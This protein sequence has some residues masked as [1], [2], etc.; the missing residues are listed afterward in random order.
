M[1]RLML[2][3][4]ASLGYATGYAQTATPAPDAAKPDKDTHVLEKFVVT[5]SNIPMASDQLAVPMT[6]I[7]SDQI[8]DSGEATS[9]LDLLRKISP[10]ISGI[11]EENATIS[12]AA[13]YGGSLI[14]L[15]GLSVLILVN[16]HRVA[17]SA[18]EAVGGDRFE[19]LNMIPVGAIDSIEVLA[20]GASALYG[21]E[22]VGG[23]INVK[24]KKDFNGWEANAHY[25][26]SDNTG[27]YAEQSYSLVGGVSNGKTTVTIAAEYAKHDPIMFSQRPYTNPYYANDYIPG[28]IDIYN[29]ATNVDEIYTLN[30]KYNAP[31]GGAQYTIAQLISMGYYI[32]QGDASNPATDAKVIPAI[33]N[34]ASGQTLISS[35]KRYSFVADAEHK[36]FDDNRL[37]FFTDILYAD[38]K[39]QTSLNA[40]P[41]YPYVSTPYQD[42]LN[43]VSSPPPAGVQYVPYTIP[44]NPFSQ[45][46]MDQAGDFNTGF[47]VVAHDRLIQYPR[48]FYNDSE[49]LNVN[50]GFRGDASDKFSWETSTNL[51]R[52]SIAYA[53]ENVIDATNFYAALA[54]G[55]LN[56]FAITQTPGVLPGNI[57]G[58]ATMNGVS[59]LGQWLVKFNGTA[60]SIPGGDVLWAAGYTFTRETL[61]AT[62]DLNTEDKG[63]V[64][65]PS[66][67]PV[68]KSRTS[69]AYY[70]EA[71]IPIFGKGLSFPGMHSLNLDIAGRIEDYQVV[72]S[73]RVPKV[74]LKYEPFDDQFS[75]RFSAGKSFVA[76]TLYDLYGPVNVGSSNDI[77]Y[78]P[79]GSSTALPTTQFEAESGSNVNLKP[80]TAETWTAGFG[81]TPNA[82]KGLTIT[83]DFFD[84]HQI[85][86]PGSVDQQTIIQSVENLGPASPYDSYVHFGT[87]TGA[88]PTA[89]GQIST[90]PKSS[91]WI[92]APT[93]NLGGT[94]TRGA[95]AAVEYETREGTWGKLD[96][97]ATGVI[98]NTVQ[99][100][101]IPT[102]PYYNYLGNSSQN[103]GTVPHYKTYTTLD[104]KVKHWKVTLANFYVPSIKDV[105]S[106]GAN[107]TATPT[108]VNSYTQ[109]DGSIGYT[110]KDELPA[111]LLNGMTI[112]VGCS[113]IGNKMPPLSKGAQT[114]TN[115]DVGFYGGAVG[116]LTY[117]NLDYKF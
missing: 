32:D 61:S 56:P 39:T 1:V 58:T 98:Y 82:V 20:D 53:N 86:L 5:G 17:T 14:N 80:S 44:G 43:G 21:S 10:A 22:A 11:G 41:L 40:Q 18:A 78:T 25:G 112:T 7:L 99:L 28:V 97:K 59:T 83:Y 110:F 49:M 109:F 68:I 47:D 95:D 77:V 15:H 96:F 34:F 38:T 3:A 54:A 75:L 87:V 115:A 74:A 88:N 27:N 48:I 71:N 30:P 84:T 103:E 31:P 12:T 24:L 13:T 57:L 106:G 52:Y 29:I 102:Q 63:W 42:A 101:E 46:W 79:Y 100:D 60:F 72:G 114:Q 37:T 9:T 6:A 105:G 8:A 16:G 81:L 35:L 117:V 64:N 93:I 33:F 89:P 51:S 104:W 85:G 94:L 70:A 113:N 36:I 62:A 90:H 73:S 65:S 55:T 23:V 4:L 76:P 45:A 19:D 69:N 107:A 2:L 111:H 92:F 26:R 66:I 67:L 116:R 108:P 50:A 91:V